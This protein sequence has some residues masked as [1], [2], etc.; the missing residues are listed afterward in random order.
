MSGVVTVAVV[1]TGAVTVTAVIGVTTVTVAAGAATLA[2]KVGICGVGR[3]TLGNRTVEVDGVLDASPTAC[4]D[5][6]TALSW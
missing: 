1:P 3:A 2:G 6:G 5:P 4:V